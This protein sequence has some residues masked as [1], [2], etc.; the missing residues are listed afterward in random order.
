MVLLLPKEQLSTLLPLGVTLSF[1]E[2]YFGPQLASQFVLIVTK[3]P[4]LIQTPT[5]LSWGHERKARSSEQTLARNICRPALLVSSSA[6][7][8][9]AQAQRPMP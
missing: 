6:A 8:F 5:A 4:S 3:E 2:I 1:Q 7:V 9:S